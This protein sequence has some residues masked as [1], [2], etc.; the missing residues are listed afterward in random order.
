LGE[1]LLGDDAGENHHDEEPPEVVLL[2][3]IGESYVFFFLLGIKRG[4]DGE[5]AERTTSEFGWIFFAID[6][7]NMGGLSKVDL[8]RNMGYGALG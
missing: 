1:P 7:E 8:H 3:L 4:D 6:R 5:V 2:L